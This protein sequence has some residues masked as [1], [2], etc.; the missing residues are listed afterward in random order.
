MV[1]AEVNQMNRT[2]RIEPVQMA[3]TGV[4]YFGL[5]LASVLRPEALVAR[6]GK[7]MRERDVT[8]ARPQR[9]CEMKTT[10]RAHFGPSRLPAHP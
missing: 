7:I 10:R 1:I 2:E 4:R 9:N 3:A 5:T 6:E 8:V